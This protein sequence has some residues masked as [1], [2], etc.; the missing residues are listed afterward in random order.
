MNSKAIFFSLAAV[1]AGNAAAQ[2]VACDLI[3]SA[4]VTSV[5]ASP[6]T[7]QFPNRQTQP[8]DGAVF[9]VCI[10]HTA[11]NSLKVLLFDFPSEK[12]A[13]RAFARSTANGQDAKFQEETALGDAA[14]SWRIDGAEAY[15]YTV[16]KGKRVFT[17]D[18]RWYDA[19]VGAGPKERLKPVVASVL[20]KL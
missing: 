15:G 7:Q 5:F 19:A 16:R 9:S 10:F 3:D 1:V 17:L 11:R 8:M 4:T 14:A 13:S 6:I 20:R 2:V 12:E 18:T